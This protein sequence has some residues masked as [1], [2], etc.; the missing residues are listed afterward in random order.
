MF[1]HTGYLILYYIIGFLIFYRLSHENEAF[2]FIDIWMGYDKN[3]DEVDEN[4]ENLPRSIGEKKTSKID[5]FD[6]SFLVSGC[7]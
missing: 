4:K 3:P 7:G 1:D 2:V 6:R 5:D